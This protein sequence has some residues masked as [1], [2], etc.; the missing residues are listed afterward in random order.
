MD[1]C[2]QNG[3]Y[4]YYFKCRCLTLEQGEEADSAYDKVSIEVK[5]Q[6]AAQSRIPTSTEAQGYL[7]L[8]DFSDKV[9]FLKEGQKAQP[10][11]KELKAYQKISSL[12]L[13]DL[14]YYEKVSQ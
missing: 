10:E 5:G 13:R 9:Y 14:R 4:P 1:A 6:Q 7:N 8:R 12:W 2:N 11:K 3:D